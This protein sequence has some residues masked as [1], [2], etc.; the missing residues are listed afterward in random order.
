MARMYDSGTVRRAA[1]KARAPQPPRQIRDSGVQ[2]DANQAVRRPVRPPS[3]SGV[4]GPLQ[5]ADKSITRAQRVAASRTQRARRQVEAHTTVPYVPKVAHATPGQRE[6]A[7][8]AARTAYLQG[9]H[10]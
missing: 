6:A 2:S 3:R 9:I 8:Q 5:R 10:S 1:P 4:F 7:R